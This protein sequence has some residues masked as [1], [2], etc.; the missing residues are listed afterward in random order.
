MLLS[1]NKQITNLKLVA[2]TVQTEKNRKKL[3]QVH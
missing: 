2:Q 3:L 1:I